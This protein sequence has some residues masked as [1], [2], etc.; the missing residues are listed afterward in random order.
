MV[1]TELFSSVVP[2]SLLAP[3]RNPALS[4]PLMRWMATE[5][6]ATV[7]ACSAFANDAHTQTT[8]SGG[9]TEFLLQ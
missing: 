3:R 1:P 5:G 4:K 8:A 2:R 6:A 9:K 7:Q